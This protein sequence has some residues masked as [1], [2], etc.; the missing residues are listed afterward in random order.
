MAHTSWRCRFDGARRDA[1]L[2]NV[3]QQ[4]VDVPRRDLVRRPI[5]ERAD[6]EAAVR[7]GCAS[8]DRARLGEQVA[9]VAQGRGLRRAH[10]LE[11][12]DVRVRH[13]PERRR[14]VGGLLGGGRA[15][16]EF[17]LDFAH[18]LVLGDDRGVLVEVAGLWATPAA[19]KPAAAIRLEPRGP[20]PSLHRPE[21]AVWEPVPPAGLVDDLAVPGDADNQPGGG[22]R[23]LSGLETRHDQRSRY[24]AHK[25]GV[26]LK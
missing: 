10:P 7:L 2:G 12:V 14:R 11:P 5:A 3:G 24:R 4:P 23:A 9:V 1:G 19:A 18:E 21:P 15:L 25:T 8:M 17:A 22:R 16:G 6:D 13:G 26:A 20:E